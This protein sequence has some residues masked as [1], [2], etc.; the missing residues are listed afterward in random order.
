MPS[1]PS[2]APSSVPP[3]TPSG[4]PSSTPSGSAPLIDD[5]GYV[6]D[7]FDVYDGVE[8]WVDGG[9]HYGSWF[10]GPCAPGRHPYYDYMPVFD[11]ET[12][13]IIDEIE[14]DTGNYQE[15]RILAG[16]FDSIQ[17]AWA[18]RDANVHH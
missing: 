2:G 5:K 6:Y 18:W 13:E 9:A 11:D 8:T 4:A 14:I 15:V 7:I 1:T 10:V 12:G 16:P 3:S 17:E